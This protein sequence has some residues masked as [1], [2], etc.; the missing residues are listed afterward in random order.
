[1]TQK[2]IEKAFLQIELCKEQRDLLRFLWF[3]DPDKIEFD[4]FENNKIVEY[5]LCRVIMGATPS[6]FLVS[7]TLQHHMKNYSELDPDFVIKYFELFTC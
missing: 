5:R 2:D 4:V 1:M 6:P 3:K 7:A